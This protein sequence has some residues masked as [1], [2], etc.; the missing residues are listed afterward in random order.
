MRINLAYS[1][2]N[3]FSTYPQFAILTDNE[4]DEDEDEDGA[5]EEEET[6]KPSKKASKK[7]Q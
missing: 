3:N 1:N 5:E 7:L 4:E 6:K 2:Q